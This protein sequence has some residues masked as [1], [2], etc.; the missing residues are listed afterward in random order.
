MTMG[1]L[2]GDPERIRPHFAE[3]KALLDRIAALDI[4][5]LR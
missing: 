1:P 5:T 2:V 3:T 4:R